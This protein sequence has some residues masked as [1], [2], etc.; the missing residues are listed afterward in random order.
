M[1]LLKVHKHSIYTWGG[2]KYCVHISYGWVPL[3]TRTCIYLFAHCSSITALTYLNTCTYVSYTSRIK[4]RMDESESALFCSIAKLVKWA[5][6]DSRGSTMSTVNGKLVR[7]WIQEFETAL[8]V[9]DIY[10][11][12]CTCVYIRVATVL[13]CKDPIEN[14]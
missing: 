4:S 13:P 2:R 10:Y 14:V 1:S 5:D 7:V 6:F 11:C 9:S 3:Y 12:T 8:A